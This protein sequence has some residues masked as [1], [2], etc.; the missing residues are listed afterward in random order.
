M[1]RKGVKNP[2]G[3]VEV[4]RQQSA[5]VVPEQR[6]ETG[7]DFPGEMARHDIFREREQFAL[8][9]SGICPTALHRR[10]PATFSGATVLP[11]QGIDVLA[12]HKQ[13]P[14]E[15]DLLLRR[16]RVVDV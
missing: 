2:A 7:L 3:T 14:I 12:S 10:A 9:A 1:K 11:P 13:R 4:T 16:R 6:V 8:R 5:A 15:G